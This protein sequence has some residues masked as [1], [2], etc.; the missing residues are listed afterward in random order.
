[1]RRA[2]E[3]GTPTI[4]A[5]VGNPTVVVDETADLTDASEKILT[6]ASYNNGTSCSSESNVLV[7]A[8]IAAGSP[9]NSSAGAPTCAPW[10]RP[11]A[12]VL[13]SGPTAWH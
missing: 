1:M 3:S 12:Y 4:G 6:G 2:Y 10:R 13:C 9:P 5:G 11:L 7:H 8:S